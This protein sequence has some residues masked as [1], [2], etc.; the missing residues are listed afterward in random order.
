[1]LIIRLPLDRGRGLKA[2]IFINFSSTA[3]RKY[4]DDWYSHVYMNRLVV[5]H[6]LSEANG[7]T[8]M[9]VTGRFEAG[10]TNEGRRQAGRLGA[11]LRRCGVD[12]EHEAVAVSEMA[13]SQETARYAGF[14]QLHVV[15]V[16]NEAATIEPSAQVMRRAVRGE[17]PREVL[18]DA[19][20]LLLD[21]PPE[22][23]W[24]THGLIIAGLRRLVGA[25]YYT[26][27]VPNF[28]EIT[29]LDI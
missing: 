12:T 14:S 22:T 2:A 16:L 7:A 15:S 4:T 25:E 13:R 6:A 17:L 29:E 3:I 11:W 20:T 18:F 27:Y 5:R 1:M 19:E 10:L 23:L 24:V 8:G 28:C 26:R 21:P 9:T